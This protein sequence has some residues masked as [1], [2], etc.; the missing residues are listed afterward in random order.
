MLG[1]G[2]LSS[3]TNVDDM[4]YIKTISS[5]GQITL[6]QAVRERLRVKPGDFVT[7]S[8]RRELLRV[9]KWP[10]KRVH[11]ASKALKRSTRTRPGA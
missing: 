10:K 6:P 8:V 11:R 4:H 1:R 5:K 3:G 9:E 7:L 2:V